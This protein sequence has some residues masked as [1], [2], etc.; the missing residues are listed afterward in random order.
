M[1]QSCINSLSI[2]IKIL[3]GLLS[4]EFKWGQLNFGDDSY[5]NLTHP[6]LH[7]DESNFEFGLVTQRNS[8]VECASQGM[9]N[10]IHKRH[11]IQL[12]YKII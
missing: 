11:L 12:H 6:N 4:L 1:C 3:Y 2:I 10:Q 5:S 9:S 8:F 7:N